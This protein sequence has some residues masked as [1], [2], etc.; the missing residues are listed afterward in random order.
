MLKIRQPLS[1]RLIRSCRKRLLKYIK[2][3]YSE[4]Q[5]LDLLNDPRIAVDDEYAEY[6]KT[7]D[8]KYHLAELTKKKLKNLK[9]LIIDQ[10]GDHP[11][12]INRSPCYSYLNG[13][14]NEYERY[15][16]FKSSDQRPGTF[17]HKSDRYD[18]LI[19]SLAK[20]GYDQ[21]KVIIV[22]FNNEILDGHHR[23]CWLWSEYGGDF[24]VTVLKIW[25]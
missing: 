24:Q 12:S 5:Y 17:H 1:Y 25:A 22:N 14:K 11:E 2:L 15:C 3:L 10:G 8:F 20:T 13:D 21:K 6:W 9:V 16:V 7:V 18:A 19:N 4:K 23:A